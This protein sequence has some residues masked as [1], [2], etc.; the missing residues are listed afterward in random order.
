MRLYRFVRDTIPYAFGPWGVRASETLAHGTGTCTNKANLLVALARAAGIG[1]AYGVRR[2]DTQHYFGPIGPYFLTRRA[3]PSSVHVHAALHVDGR[4]LKCD[5]S[6]DSDLASRTCHFCLQTR[7]I[8]WD[9]AE[10]SIDFLDPAYVHADLGLYADVDEL[11]DRPA[12]GAGPELFAAGNS[13][14]PATSNPLPLIEEA[15]RQPGLRETPSGS[16]RPHAKTSA[17]DAAFSSA[18]LRRRPF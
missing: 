2:V 5:P 1:V 16:C 10:D 15:K 8:V 18:L 6:T 14:P 17:C 11:L 9:G 3:S 12:R 7:L 13:T 4:W